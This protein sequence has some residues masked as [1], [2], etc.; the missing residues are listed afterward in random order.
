MIILKE[1]YFIFFIIF[2]NIMSSLKPYNLGIDT[3]AAALEHINDWQK[4]YESDIP[5]LF[6]E[7]DITKRYELIKENHLFNILDQKGLLNINEKGIQNLLFED[8]LSYL[9]K[10]NIKLDLLAQLEYGF[11]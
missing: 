6:E 9:N 3:Y 4:R 11:G 5:E 1:L 8:V 10:A 2:T 7:L